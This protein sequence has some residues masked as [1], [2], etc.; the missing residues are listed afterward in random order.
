MKRLIIVA[1]VLL[2]SACTVIYHD[3]PLH[4]DIGLAQPSR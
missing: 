3:G 1:L 2:T 4:V